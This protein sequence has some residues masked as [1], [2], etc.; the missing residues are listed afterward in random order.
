MEAKP[1]ARPF[2]ITLALLA[3]LTLQ[4]RFDKSPLGPR[5]TSTRD[6]FGDAADHEADP[7]DP[8]AQ[9]DDGGPESSPPACGNG[10]RTPDEACDDGNT[11][12]GD[13]CSADCSRI[14]RGYSCENAGAA[15]ARVVRCGDGIIAAGEAC[16]DGNNEGGD[17]CSELCGAEPG[18]RC[19]GQPSEC[20]ALRC[21]DGYLDG[22]EN[23]DDGNELPFDGCS[24]TCQIEP[25]CKS[26]GCVT[27]CGDGL[28]LDEDCDDGNIQD[29][30][31]CSSSCE[32]EDGFRCNT[33]SA[34]TESP[35]TLTIN[36]LYR[37]F[38]VSHP[39]FG[40][41]CGDP[42]KGVVAERLGQDGKPVLVDGSKVCIRSRDTFH[43]WYTN[44]ANNSAIPGK[45]TLYDDGVGGYVN[46]FGRN[47]EPWFGP[48]TYVNAQFGGQAGGG[49][50][51]CRLSGTAQC[52][53][54]CVPWKTG[55][56]SCCA[57]EQA[58]LPYDGTPLFFP[59][60]G[61]PNALDDERYR[62]K[63]PAEYGYSGWPWED[64][65]FPGAPRHNFHFTTEVVHWF[66][67][68]PKVS[69]R[70]DFNG[71]DDMW[72]FVNGRLAVDLGGPH[73]PQNGAVTLDPS[74]ADR[75]GL[76]EGKVYQIH[77]FHAERKVEGSTFRLT[78]SGL[79]T[80]RSVCVNLLQ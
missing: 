67:Y 23:C 61:A 71:D 45:L 56:V 49:C 47:G 32:V 27:K 80:A 2:W 34:C 26:G 19:S 20:V 15:C 38:N 78:L 73:V 39:D 18:Y 69:S 10:A 6:T 1:R 72:V 13:G 42:T 14:E 4:C 37:D 12:S 11:E 22:A 9:E 52:F 44:N 70:L 59:I 55:D 17:G 41:D 65:I 75:F 35:C 66:R 58:P 74:T 5:A 60:D 76:R 33:E 48:E 21:G 51:R 68:D 28:V 53:D 62:A 46:R 36:V 54:P 79:E 24:A 43:E 7:V 3:S 77:V 8:P 50:S 25:D 40:V 31:G 64:E 57:I 63:V 30:D 16:D 29:G